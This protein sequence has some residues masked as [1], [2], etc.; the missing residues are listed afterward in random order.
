MVEAQQQRGG[1]RLTTDI[2]ARIAKED[3]N[4]TYTPKGIYGLLDR[5]GMSHISI[6]W[7]SEG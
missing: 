6:A 7:A 5:I 3:F 2:I 1:G 4:A